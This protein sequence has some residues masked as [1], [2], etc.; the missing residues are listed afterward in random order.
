MMAIY[1]REVVW[2]QVLCLE[3]SLLHNSRLPRWSCSSRGDMALI[4][5][6]APAGLSDRFGALTASCR[7]ATSHKIH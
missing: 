6:S 7:P 3:V 4:V 1:K 2:V 5:G